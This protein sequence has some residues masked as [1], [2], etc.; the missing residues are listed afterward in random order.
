M[1]TKLRELSAIFLWILVFAFLGLMVFE[2]GMDYSGITGRSN[3]VGRVNDE[4]ITYEVFTDM[5]QQAYQNE[6]A[7]TEKEMDE[8]Q[9]Q[10][11]RNQVWE[12]FVQRTL[13]S[14]EMKKLNIA[15]S[16]SEVVY[17]IQHYPLEEIKNNPIFQ[18]DGVFD[19]NKYRQSF[20]NPNMPWVQIEEF[21]RAQI[22]FQKL[23][24]IIAS[25]VRVSPSEV[26]EEFRNRNEKVKVEYLGIPYSKFNNKDITVSEEEL[27]SYYNEHLED[28]KREETRRLSYVLFPLKPSAKD[29]QRVLRDFEEIKQKLAAGEDFNKLADIYSED[30]AVQQNHGLYD[31]FERGSMVKPFE[32][33]AFSGKVGE[34]VGPVKTRYG[35]HL[36]RIE[37]KRIKD[38][39]EQVKAS[40]ILLNYTVSPSTREEIDYK[41]SN[42]AEEAREAGLEQAAE[43]ADLTVQTTGDLTESSQFIPGFGQNYAISRFAF[44]AE[45]GDLSEIFDTDKGFAIFK[46]ESIKEAGY[47]PFDEVRNL[48]ENRVKFEKAKTRTAEFAQTV[49]EKVNQGTPFSEIAAA[50]KDKI[51]QTGVTDPFTMKGSVK[52]VGYSNKFNA[53]AFS[54]EL[55]E[56]TGPVETNRG[57]YYLRCLEKVAADTSLLAAQSESIERQL[58]VRKRNKVFQEWYDSLKEKAT[59]VDNRKEFNL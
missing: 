40:H 33:A 53:A 8:A 28:Y 23:Q 36:I 14:E 35:L 18:T 46:L 43:K 50:D 10:Q 30:P 21:Y 45:V 55:N 37:D 19:W 24:N 52:G 59:I 44:S 41:A 48:I 54:L 25:T 39:K 32:D 22:P 11:L 9:L 4:E 29:S 56:V 57:L 26:E 7:R 15:V 38:G 58:L 34:I 27:R 31:Y 20:T 42:F 49:T 13:F 17:Q 6:R 3:V 5:Y 1:M 47:R 12:Q 16:D 2:W 51:L